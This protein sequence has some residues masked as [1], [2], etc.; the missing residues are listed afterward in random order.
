MAPLTLVNPPGEK[1]Q[2]SDLGFETIGAIIAKVS[3]QSFEDYIR[4]HIFLPLGMKNSSFLLSDIPPASLASPHEVNKVISVSPDFPYSRQHAPSSHLFSNVQDMNR[5]AQAQLGRGQLG[6]NRILPA[7][8][9]DTMWAP[10][11]PT[12]LHSPWEKTLGLGWF[13]GEHAGHRLVGHG[14]GDT[15]FSCGFVMAP[16]D[17]L[18]VVVMINRLDSAEDIAFNIMQWLLEADATGNPAH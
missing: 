15:G 9:Y 18:A 8:A 12:A 11:I 3:G 5:F 2:Y 17:G 1:M 4:D 6:W 13:L 16:D 7:K 14:G 10:E